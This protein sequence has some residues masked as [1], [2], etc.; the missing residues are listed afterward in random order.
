MHKLF[1]AWLRAAG[2]EPNDETS[3]K[4]W[5]VI[6]EYLPTA[7]EIIS[8]AR[9]FYGFSSQGDASLDKFGTALQDIDTS[10]SMQDHKR[11]L[12]V[13][14]G[15]ELIATIE[16]DQDER[17][18]D[19]AALC[20]VCGGAQGARTAVPVPEMPKIAARYIENRTG[21]RASIPA[22]TAK[23][24]PAPR[25]E[26][27]ERELTI[28]GEES[29]M[30]WWLVSEYS[31]DRN[32][33]WKKVGLSATSIIAG[34]ELADLTR[35][36]PGPVAAA[37][38]LDRMVRLSDSAESAKPISVKEAIEKTPREWRDQHAFKPAGGLD[39]LAPINNAI[40]LSLAVSDGDDWSPVFEK[41]TALEANSKMLPNALTY[42]GFLERLL[43]R[44]SG[45]VG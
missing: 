17:L 26:K 7:N 1:S 14:A 11:H 32:Q 10:F 35:I 2:L 3:P 41:G 24:E 39:D 25:I 8:F 20:L 12:S 28:V 22:G 45:E 9:F 44:L 21:K 29:N 13:F 27:L 38:F 5:K 43:A 4:H 40:K 37:A 33:S 16:R 6:S 18:A 42:Q 34:K 15:A 31:R 36:I 19:L 23:E 30:L